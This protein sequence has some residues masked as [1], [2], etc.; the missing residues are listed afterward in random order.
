M[1]FYFH[2]PRTG[3]FSA[4]HDRCRS[5]C[6][7]HAHTYFPGMASA[8]LGE[9]GTG[10]SSG[11]SRH[12]DS[13]FSQFIL[14]T[15]GTQSGATV[16]PRAHAA[17]E[18]CACC[19]LSAAFVPLT[20]LPCR[21]GIEVLSLTASSTTNSSR[22]HDF[23]ISSTER[24]LTQVFFPISYLKNE[25]QQTAKHLY[26]FALIRWLYDLLLSECKHIVVCDIFVSW[27]S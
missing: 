23:M 24:Y 10:D 9:L 5:I 1:H 7:S 16:E 2:L 20:Q 8:S 13:I 18:K 26:T 21:H 4:L 22:F 25:H 6:I 11:Q 17:E 3:L 14:H 12:V 27:R 15:L 19:S